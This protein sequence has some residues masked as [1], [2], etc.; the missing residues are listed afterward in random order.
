[1]CA[2][3]SH[4]SDMVLCPQCD[5]VVDVPELARGTKAEC[6]RCHT[7]LTARWREPRRQP[8][9]YALCGLVMF[10]LAGMFPF[11]SMKVAGIESEITIYQIPAV[12][13]G[14]NYA[15]LALFFMG[16]VLAVPVYCLAAIT[17]LCNGIRLPRWLAVPVTKLLF[18]LRTWCMAEIF[19]AGV[20]VSFVKLMAYG[21]IGLGMSFLPYCLFCVMQVRA[22]QCLDKYWIWERIAP[23]PALSVP[24]IAGKGGLAQGVRLCGTCQAILPAGMRECPRCHSKGHARR[25]NSLQLTL[26]L[27]FTSV[28]LYIPANL[29][30][31]MITETLGNGFG[32]TIMAGVILLWGDGSYPVAMVIFIASIMVPSLKMLAI[33]WL[34]LD[35]KGHGMRDPGRMHFIYEIVE[36]V[37]RWSMIDVFVI[38]VLAALVRMGR[39]MS[40]YPDIGV[41]LFALVVVLT[42]I[43]AEMFDPRLTWDRRDKQRAKSSEEPQLERQK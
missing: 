15:E 29:L 42:M 31:I 10:V 5:L 20:L 34:C 41:I 12:M 19:L 38:A 27:L 11:V 21:D 40:I 9:M 35:A 36:F 17:L 4:D 1:M 30:P 3:H 8:L 43:A 14:D 28:I 7:H 6:P 24:L 26:A 25:P 39:L 23:R 2:H 33:G 22:F 32:S 18:R 16:F 13:F 37:G